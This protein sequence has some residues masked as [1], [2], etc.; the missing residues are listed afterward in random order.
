MTMSADSPAMDPSG[1]ADSWDASDAV[2]KQIREHGQLLASSKAGATWCEPSRANAIKNQ[3]VM[4]PALQILGETPG[5]KLPYTDPLMAVIRKFLEKMGRTPSD[6]QVYQHTGEMKKMLS[7]VKRRANHN[8][9][10]KVRVTKRQLFPLILLF[11]SHQ[12]VSGL[13]CVNK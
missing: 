3:A 11:W 10:T 5:N 9:F 4:I 6:K 8:E 1:L 12:D 13:R 2:R 7:F